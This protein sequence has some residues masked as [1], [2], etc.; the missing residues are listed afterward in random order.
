M[1]DSLLLLARY[2]GFEALDKVESITFHLDLI[3]Y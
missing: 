2:V 1:I 3:I